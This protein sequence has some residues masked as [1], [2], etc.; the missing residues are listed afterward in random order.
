MR[1]A[2][3]LIFVAAAVLSPDIQT[4]GS[5]PAIRVEQLW[6][7]ALLVPLGLYYLENPTL[8]KIHLIDWAFLALALAISASILLTPVI[9][10]ES[11]RSIRD[12]FEVAR[13]V[14]YWAAFRLALTLR[15]VFETSRS[16]VV[17]LALAG[18]GSGIFAA[19]QYLD[20]GSFNEAVTDVWA[21]SHNLESVI[22]R[23]RSVG[24]VGN[25][26]NFGIFCTLLLTTL[27][28]SMVLRKPGNLDRLA[29]T[30][31]VGGIA[32]ATVG[33]MASQSRTATIAALGAVVLT[34]AWMFLV[35]GKAGAYVPVVGILVVSLA[36]SISLLE[37]FPPQFGRF[38]DRFNPAA[39]TDDPSIT[40]RITKWKSLFSG[41]FADKPDFC[42]GEDLDSLVTTGHEPAAG[43][44]AADPDVAAR[45]SERKDD[46]RAV[47]RSMLDYFCENDRWPVADPTGALVPEFLEVLPTDPQT[48]EAYALY[49]QRFGFVVSAVLENSDD[50]VGPRF[51]LGTVPNL[52]TNPSFEEGGMTPS[53]W[54]VAGAADGRGL[55]VLARELEGRFGDRAASATIG[56]GG[57]VWQ[58]IVLDFEP[59]AEYTA[60]AWARAEGGSDERVLLYLVGTLANGRTL[61]PLAKEEAIL[62]ATG[63]WVPISLTFSTPDDTRL[64][65]IQIM[66]R[67]SGTDGEVKAGFDALM[68]TPGT[69]SP[70]FPW[71]RNVAPS[72]SAPFPG[73]SDSPLVGVG[74]RKGLELGAFDNEY[75]LFLDRYGILGTLSYLFLFGAAFLVSLRV[76]LDSRSEF[77]W[78][79]VGL[80]AFIAALAVYN[81]TAGSYYSFQLMAIFWPLVGLL[82]GAQQ[83]TTTGPPGERRT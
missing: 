7:A 65:T 50:P 33:L 17:V 20:V 78:L 26:N 74:P 44:L 30:L 81:L 12:P 62:S 27:L 49:V 8:R 38:H 48:G 41:F 1:L 15:P 82:A 47:S 59:G 11:F 39:F 43:S 4:P 45:D 6:L 76:S 63:R 71:I 54:S 61:D 31:L 9:V 32:F 3:T 46:I 5:L 42:T 34:F 66:L 22:R 37:L 51:A 79:G 24:F 83:G 10:E 19:V 58:L 75:V 73:F 29:Q 72:V 57:S 80:A 67:S 21:N 68:L 18:T 60:S 77:Q 23:G 64:S 36:V 28:S 35:R 13:V 55:T 69:I 53:H 52:V 40:I 25:P 70:S 2:A 56:D 16:T 14:E